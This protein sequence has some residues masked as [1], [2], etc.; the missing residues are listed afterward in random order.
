MLIRPSE[1]FADSELQ[2]RGDADDAL[3]ALVWNI[4]SDT[5]WWSDNM[6]RLHGYEPSAIQPSL[7]NIFEHQHPAD[8]ERGERAFERIKRDARPFVFEHRVITRASHLRTV[9]LAVSATIGTSGRP[10]IATGVCLDVSQA[11]RIHHAAAEETVSGLHDAIIR[12]NARIDSQNVINQATGVL[13]ERHKIPAG[14]A[15]ELLRK[16]S[17]IAGRRLYEVASELLFSGQLPAGAAPPSRKAKPRPDFG[18]IGNRVKSEHHKY[19]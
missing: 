2:I 9:I 10:D 12:L 19:R 11:L 18:A 14:E 4:P 17:Q 16:A 3:P 5:V 13:M 1:E 6:Y 8:R 7:A 15:S